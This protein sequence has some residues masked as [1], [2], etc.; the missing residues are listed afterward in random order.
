MTGPE[1]FSD[2][3]IPFLAALLGAGVGAG[4]ALWAHRG[5]VQLQRRTALAQAPGRLV[6]D[7][8][9]ISRVAASEDTY[10]KA[11]L[12][13]ARVRFNQHSLAVV[14]LGEG[15]DYDT[16]LRH[17]GEAGQQ[18]MWWTSGRVTKKEKNDYIHA[19]TTAL[20]QEDPTRLPDRLVALHSKFDGG[21]KW[22]QET[23]GA[24]PLQATYPADQ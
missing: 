19:L 16:L 20:R 2:Y 8:Y 7:L 21:A 4:I 6:S 24:D 9:E 18:L 1:I 22:R 10:D 11:S 23:G 5:Q 12:R 15:D 14:M 13:A 17:F 3:V